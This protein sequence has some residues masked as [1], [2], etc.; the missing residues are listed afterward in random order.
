MSTSPPGHVMK[1]CA[2]WLLMWGWVGVLLEWQEAARRRGQEEE[3][4]GMGKA[5][6]GLLRLNVTVC[7]CMCVLGLFG[8]V[9]VKCARASADKA[10]CGVSMSARLRIRLCVSVGV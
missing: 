8:S 3:E 4:A 7:L 10:V 6:C 2:K 1:A 5:D 9:H